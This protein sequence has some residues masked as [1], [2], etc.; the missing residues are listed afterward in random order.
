MQVAL[1]AVG[2]SRCGFAQDCAANYTAGDVERSAAFWSADDPA[3]AATLAM[4]H[5]TARAHCTGRQ[6]ASKRTN[7]G[8]WCLVQSAHPV[9][10]R[11][12]VH[13]ESQ[14]VPLPHN[15]SYVLPPE[16]HPA[17]MP[18]A[19]FGPAV[20]KAVRRPRH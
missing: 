16:H 3:A 11:T 20:E 18:A 1:C 2:A 10:N 15:H 9:A 14:L 7:T 5:A 19:L 6:Y 12:H 17:E 8:G 4:R 13:R